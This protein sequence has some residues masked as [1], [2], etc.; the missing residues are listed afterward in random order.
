MKETSPLSSDNDDFRKEKIFRIFQ[1]KDF[2][3]DGK[4]SPEDF[5]TWGRLASKNMSIEFT[6]EKKKAWLAAHEAYFGNGGSESPEKYYESILEFI[7]LENHVE[8]ATQVN[9]TLFD[10][11][12]AD[13]D[14]TVS[15][16]EYRAFIQPL[17][18]T[19]EED[20]RFGFD[21]IDENKDGV[22][23]KEE[24]SK[25]CCHYYFDT[26]ATPYMNFYG[27]YDKKEATH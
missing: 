23:S 20:I 27:K 13:G 24:I 14:G 7:K 25:A 4:V 26:E 1:I 21:C 6:D 3:G 17:G 18:I 16:D 15:I 22:L 19:N 2:D 8:L 9:V 11:L 5:V 12:D 10:C